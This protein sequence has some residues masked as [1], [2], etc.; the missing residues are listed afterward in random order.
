VRIFGLVYVEV[1]HCYAFECALED[2]LQVDLKPKHI[3]VN[4]TIRPTI[5]HLKFQTKQT[6]IQNR[7]IYS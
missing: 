7:D 5:F 3:V 4:D 2:S 6:Y 1:T